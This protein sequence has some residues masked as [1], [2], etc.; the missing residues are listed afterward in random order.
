MT[1][2][3]GS[4]SPVRGRAAIAVVLLAFL[5]LGAATLDDYGL[6]WDEGVE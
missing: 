5:A 2:E 4:P 3:N 6:S 1:A